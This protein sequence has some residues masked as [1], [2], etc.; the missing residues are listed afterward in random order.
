MKNTREDHPM[1]ETWWKRKIYEDYPAWWKRKKH[2]DYPTCTMQQMQGSPHAFS[3][4]PCFQSRVVFLCIFH[5]CLVPILFIGSSLHLNNFYR[6]FLPFVSVVFFGGG[7]STE[8]FNLYVS[9]EIQFVKIN[10]TIFFTCM[11]NACTCY[12]LLY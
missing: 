7:S 1:T 11:W 12:N 8:V 6:I 4:L 10:K 5:L 2:K 3:F 9:D